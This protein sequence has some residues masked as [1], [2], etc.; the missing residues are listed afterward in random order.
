MISNDLVLP[1]L[2]RRAAATTPK[3]TRDFT[4]TI[5]NLRRGVV[6]AILVTAF[7]YQFTIQ[8]HVDFA[9]PALVFAV[10]M[11][12]LL[13]PFLGGLLWRRGTARGARWGMFG[14][15][16]VWAYT[17]VLP[18]LVG[19]SSPLLTD[20]PFGLS[21]LRPHALFGLEA[22]NYVNGL[23]WSLAANLT[24][25]I[26][27]SL[28]RSATPLERIQASVFIAENRLS[29][30]TIGNLQPG[31]TVDQLKTTISKYIGIEQTDLCVQSLSQAREYHPRRR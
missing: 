24:L 13:P 10:A 26:L 23:V 3:E 14:G 9:S 4:R 1:V 5:A 19:M 29:T 28:S 8:V 16:S 12:Q 6:A 20:G 22:S 2:L 30:N 17:M 15:F 25:F 27:G 11:M 21:A 31:V 7:A 18:T